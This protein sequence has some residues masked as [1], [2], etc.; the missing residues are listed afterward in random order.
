MAADIPTTEPSRV[1]AG[2][3]WA[4]TK[5]LDDYPA[6]TWT[7]TYPLVNSSSKITVPATASGTDHAVSVDKATTAAYAAG[8]YSWIAAVDDGTSRYTLEVGVIEIEPDL[9]I[10][11]V[12]T[13]DA[14][15]NWVKLFDAMDTALAT[16]G[17]KAWTLGYTLGDRSVTFRSHIEFLQLY[18]RARMEKYRE[19][20]ADKIARGL[21]TGQK[22]MV[23]L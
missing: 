20:L 16:F 14:R 4:W 17:S 21:G 22:V 6:P 7:L 19:E 8:T 9:A 11:G 1:R 10:A 2:D 3:T 13:Y 5:T 15:S 23:R 18:D 12:T